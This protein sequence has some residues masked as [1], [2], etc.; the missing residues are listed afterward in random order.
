MTRLSQI[1]RYLAVRFG[2]DRSP[3]GEDEQF[4]TEE[5]IAEEHSQI[6]AA[7]DWL[8]GLTD[9]EIR[10]AVAEE[11][12]RREEDDYWFDYGWNQAKEGNL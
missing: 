2:L 9:D 8:A 5:E 6:L 7:L 10:A 11:E 12:F 1:V 3:I 4:L